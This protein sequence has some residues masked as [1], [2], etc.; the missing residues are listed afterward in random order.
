MAQ[1]RVVLSECVYRSEARPC[2]VHCL[3]HVALTLIDRNVSDRWVVLKGL[4]HFGDE[5]AH[6][7]AVAERQFLA[8]VAHPGV[9]K[10][11]LFVSDHHIGRMGRTVVSDSE[12][13]GA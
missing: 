4:L 2:S 13:E 3:P 11:D 5:E 6:A 10:I 1:S 9:V 12:Q 7:V 8:E